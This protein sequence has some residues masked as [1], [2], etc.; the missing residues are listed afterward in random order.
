[1]NEI[2]VG[3]GDEATWGPVISSLD[4][5][6]V[7]RDF[8]ADFHMTIGEGNALVNVIGKVEDDQLLLETCSVWY[9]GMDIA[10]TI[11]PSTWQ[12][13]TDHFDR[14]FH[15]IAEVCA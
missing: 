15:E 3:P 12:Y 11:E 9:F 4:P 8:R 14:H 7:G 1:M 2:R 5:R 13:I 6:Y 10:E